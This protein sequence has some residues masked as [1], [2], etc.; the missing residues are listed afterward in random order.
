M[1]SNSS[2]G[3]RCREMNQDLED[4]PEDEGIPMSKVPVVEATSKSL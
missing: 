3:V 1:K 2:T 4:Q